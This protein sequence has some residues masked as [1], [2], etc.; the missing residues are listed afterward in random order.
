MYF[1]PTVNRMA[2]YAYVHFRIIFVEITV[3]TYSDEYC[4]LYRILVSF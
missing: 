3:Y 1:I 4:K 2:M